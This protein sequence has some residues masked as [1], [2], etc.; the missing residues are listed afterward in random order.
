M[1][2]L[3]DLQIQNEYGEKIEPLRKVSVVINMNSVKDTEMH[4]VH[5]VPQ[6]TGENAANDGI[7]LMGKLKQ[8]QKQA[9]TP[10]MFELPDMETV[11]VL[12]AEVT[13]FDERT[14][15]ISFETDGF[16]MY[17]IVGT[18]IEKTV[19]ASDG[20]NY[21]ITA[22][23]GPDTGIPEEAELEVNEILP[24]ENGDANTSSAYD[25]YVSKTENALGWEAGSASYARVFDIKI[26]DRNNQGVRYQPNEGTSVD[27]RIELADVKEKNELN[28][29]HFADE[30]AEGDVVA[31]S[32][33]NETD[34]SVVEFAADGFSVY[35]IINHEGEE[36]VVTPRVEFHFIAE[37]FSGTGPY[38]ASPYNFVNTAGDYQH[39]QILK[40]G[41]SLE[42]ITN[43]SNIVIDNGDGTT[44]EK[45]FY[46]WYMVNSS[47]DTSA[48]NN[49]TG[50]YEGAISYTWP[51]SDLSAVNFE[52]NLV[53]NDSENLTVGD[54]VSWT[55]GD[56]SGTGTI[57]SEGRVHVYLAPLYEDFYFINFRKGPK[58]DTT[59]LSNSLLSRR[60]IVFGSGNTAIVRIGDV[61]CPSSDPQHRIF[62]GWETVIDNDGLTR[63][64]YY[65]TVDF[66]GNE[67]DS[68]GSEDGYY[69]TV[70][71]YTSTLTQVDLYPVFAEARWLKFDTGKS[72]NGAKYV[73]SAY[74]VT[75]D[76]G[77]GNY[78]DSAF[79]TGTGNNDSHLS[80]RAGYEFEGWYAFA[81]RDSDGNITNLT[82]PQDVTVHYL[83]ETGT[84]QTITVNAKA[85]KIVNSDGTFAYDGAYN[86]DLGGGNTA[87]L[88]EIVDGKMY[89]YKAM[90]DLTLFA[91]WIVQPTTYRVIVW[92]QKVTDDK[93]TTKTP[94]DL[95]N[96]LSEDTS[97]KADDYPYTLKSYDYEIFYTSNLVDPDV[98]PDL[99]RFSGSYVDSDSTT[100]TVNNRNL[101]GENWTGFHYS[102]NDVAVVGTPNPDGT[103]VYNVYYDRDLRAINYYYSNITPS[104]DYYPAYTY[105]VTT[106]NSGTQYGIINDQYIQLT[107]NASTGKWTAPEYAYQYQID[108]TNG[109]FGKV[110]DA[111][112]ELTPKYETTTV[113]ALT[114]TLSANNDYLIV[115][116]NNAGSGYALGHSDTSVVADAVTI[117]PG[118]QVYINGDDVDN[119]SVWSVSGNYKFQNDDYYL[120]YSTKNN[121]NN[122][123]L[124]VGSNDSYN[125]WSLR[126]GN[127]NG[128][129]EGYYYDLC[130]SDNSF[131]LSRSDYSNVYLYQKT[132]DLTIAGY[133][134]DNNGTPTEYTG[135]NRYSY[136]YVPTGENTEY[137]ATRFTRSNNTLGYNY[138]LVTWSGLYGQTF[139]PNGY[140]WDNVSSYY[141]REGT[142]PGSGTGQ[143]FLDSF[144]QDTN[145]YNLVTNSNRGNF[146]LYHYKQQFDGSYTMDDRETAY[147]TLGSG[148]TTFNL[149]NKFDGFTVNSYNVGTNG[150][151][152]TG[153]SNTGSSVGIRSSDGALHVYHTR[154]KSDLTFD[155]NYPVDAN[156]VYSNGKSE[157]LTVADIYYQYPLTEYGSG[158]V[159]GKTNWYYGVV[160]DNNT[161]QHELVG[162]DHYIFG[163]WYEDASCTVPFNFDSTM[164]VGNKIVYAKWDAEWF[165]MHIDPNGA[166]IDHINHA[167]EFSRDAIPDERPADRGYDPSQ[168]TYF[169]LSYGGAISE[170]AVSRNYVP[171]SEAAAEQ[172]DGHIYYYMNH[173]YSHDLDGDY[174]LNANARNA[175]FLTEEEIAQYYAH[176]AD[177]AARA[178]VTVLDY[179]TWRQYYTSYGKQKYRI[180]K[181]QEH[182]EFLGWYQVFN[183]GTEDEYLSD[184]PYVFSTPI[185]SDLYLRAMWRLD[186]GYTVQYVPEYTMPDGAI[187]NGE[188]ENWVDPPTNNLSYADGAETE[189]YKQPTDLKKNGVSVDDDSVIFLGWQLV[190]KTGTDEH[191]VYTPL[192]SGVYYNPS[193]PYT[194]NAANAGTDSTIYFQAVYQYKDASDRRPVITNLSLDANT[195]YVNTS[196]SEDLPDWNYYPGSS[197]INTEDHLLG[198]DPTQILFGDIQ[199]SA[200]VHLYKYATELTEDASGNAMEDSHQFFTHPDGYFLLGFDDSPTEGDYVATYPSDSVIAVTRDDDKTI[201]AVWEPMVYLTLK[202]ETDVGDVIFNISSSSTEALEVINVKN[203]MYDRQP[204]SSLSNITLA[205]GESITLAF[206]K[207]AEKDITISGTNTL[208]VG[209][210]L[211]WNS[212]V[213][214]VEDG[215]TT[216]YDTAS[217]GENVI[218]SHNGDETDTH[219]LVTGEANNTKPFTFNESLVANENAVTVT[220]TSRDNAYALVLDDN[221]TGGGTQEYDYSSD[222]I[223][224]AQGVPQSQVLPSTSTRIGYEFQGW[225]YSPMAE[226]PDYSA[227]SPTG[228]PWTIPDLN[229]DDGFFSEGTT[230]VDGTVVRTLYAVWKAKAD[231]QIV[232]VY[233]DVPLP[234]N[235]DE[236]FDFTVA[237]TGTYHIRSSNTDTINESAVF[238]L[239]HGWYLKLTSSNDN[240]TASGHTTAYVQ[241]IV[242]IY[243]AEGHQQ[244]TDATVRWERTGLTSSSQNGFNNDLKISVTETKETYYDTSVT[245]NAQT[246]ANKLYIG[247]ST[248][249]ETLPLTVETNTTYWTNTDAGGTV[250]YTNTR[251]THDISVEKI[252]HSN[253]SAAAI[254]SFTA[255]YTLDGNAVDLGSFTV[256]SGITNTE[257]LKNIPAGAVLTITEVMDTN[258]IYNTTTSSAKHAED[259]DTENA[260]VFTFTVSEDDTITFNNTLKSW[261]VVFRLVDQ[262]GNPSI[263]GM[264]SLASSIGSLG[265]DLYASTTSMNPP[266]GQFYSSDTFWADTY[267]LNQT[268]IPTGYIGPNGPVTLMVTGNGI[269]SSDPESVT[270]ELNGNG[271][272]IITV[273]NRATKKVT[274]KKILIDSLLTNTRQFGFSYSYVPQ[275]SEGTATGEAVTGDFTLA[276]VSNDEDG[277][278][279]ELTVPINASVTVTE[280]NTGN[281][282]TTGTV[283]DTSVGSEDF[284]DSDETDGCVFT[285][286]KVEADGTIVFT[287]TRKTQTVTVKKVFEDSEDTIEVPFTATLL[288]G[289]NAISGYEVYQGEGGTLETDDSGKISFKLKHNE[290]QELRVPYGAKLVMEETADGYIALITTDNEVQDEDDIDNCFTMTVTADDTVTFTNRKSGINVILKKVG[291][292]SATQEI[293]ADHLGGAKFTIFEEN[294]TTVATGTVDGISGELNNLT[295]SSEDGV[296]FNGVI[297]VGTYYLHE[298]E[299][300]PGYYTPAE[301]LRMTVA[302]DGTVNLYVQSSNTTTE[303]TASSEGNAS[304]KTTEVIVKNF[305]G[306]A[307]PSTGGPGTRLVYLLGIM[308]A[309]IAG[310]GLAVKRQKSKTL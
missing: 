23:Y 268:I 46:G 171:I 234:G 122:N 137:T 27:V 139:A 242:Q 83:D 202:N 277:L 198:S 280:K 134:Y 299:A 183:A 169:W 184:M 14:W 89:L 11:Q 90:D 108:N 248:D 44:T 254:F 34:E 308:L 59:G 73:G 151:S 32:T 165:V 294:G 273:I 77:V 235:Q 287:N 238:Q 37:D 96:W 244:G 43:P 35:V 129:Y 229:A 285:V 292:D 63:D 152:S 119:T 252:L 120:R 212:S 298:T 131:E 33:E 142:T 225:A 220:F 75:N 170:Y 6:T 307:L 88:F 236:M 39:S 25:E 91:N 78:F 239:K 227:I 177:Y 17:A 68:P 209:N 58:E 16:S 102:C 12:E 262:D 143:T 29:V 306:Y 180:T 13:E 197:W 5:F 62:V 19:L 86:L 116:D 42:L 125:T 70:N 51:S 230:E 4:V 249:V 124:G 167:T 84:T 104:V 219:T 223:A 57:D 178:G 274:I 259:Q 110:G 80:S 297:A 176:Y 24:G 163:G 216:S 3:F 175:I 52:D 208:G 276:P 18:T 154:D 222:D 304:E 195:G 128:L 187:I 301:N 159:D 241:S 103:T 279:Y 61:V 118:S 79:F 9:V 135:E 291:A 148:S 53:I 100:R 185:S 155:I 182:Y 251:Q 114:S 253:T 38:T 172:Y 162:P 166:E 188:M 94:V 149:T 65:Q 218:Y 213:D 1:L 237:I 283:Y 55:L 303:F 189:I 99:T 117:N 232:Y 56:I 217:I 193:D 150:F 281:Y 50:K 275:N 64:E 203:G 107:Y 270:V 186:G 168:S 145:P 22:T 206:P 95:L 221:Y 240:A 112:V 288:N 204:L 81:N 226:T 247:E 153:G 20:L 87:K 21:R 214:L 265:T 246:E 190:S 243:D 127:R 133:T 261:P 30:E 302:A 109:T 289:A 54:T 194:V 295:S 224:P 82:D 211:I 161:A 157:N 132:T 256:Q 141:W 309:G 140:N 250:V 267:T 205:D 207:G 92:K 228:S 144:I 255:S 126:T 2:R 196:D 260:K 49:S 233:K 85:V 271:G 147:L 47:S 105:T 111:Y 200:A 156:L 269:E 71:K 138:H 7:R 305:S 278:T 26:V 10:A 115:S 45:F 130:F 257:A 266:A 31:Y 106:S 8:R 164:P 66:E 123:T 69:I 113:Y 173:Q 101:L 181:G 97:R 174:G 121:N 76:E 264:F 74:R 60:M 28:V 158:T 67:L 15:D 210:V 179:G 201:Y 215:T 160:D 263:N 199:S 191:P 41:E 293:I 231:S 72:G 40:N 310:C 300:P 98:L 146:A 290:T 136:N 192:E 284:T 272:Y 296:F 48:L 36:T 286:S 258:D 282:T 93:N 245:R